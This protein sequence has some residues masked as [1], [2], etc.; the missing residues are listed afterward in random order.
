[1][2]PTTDEEQCTRSNALNVRLPTFV[3]L[4]ETLTGHCVHEPKEMVMPTIA[5]L[6]IINCQTH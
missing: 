5:L 2:N 4:A 3:R 1:M 6:F